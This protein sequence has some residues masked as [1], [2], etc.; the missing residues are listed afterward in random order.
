M[1]RAHSSPHSKVLSEPPSRT[2][3]PRAALGS[4]SCYLSPPDVLRAGMCHF[5]V[6]ARTRV[7]AG[8]ARTQQRA[9]DTAAQ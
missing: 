2:T 8:S 7:P 1:A 4:L 9:T 3:H 6:R 5:G